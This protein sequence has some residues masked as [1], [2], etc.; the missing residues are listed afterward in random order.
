[1]KYLITFLILTLLFFSC[2]P[3]D[4]SVNNPLPTLTPPEWIKGSWNRSVD[5]LNS[6]KIVISNDDVI[7]KRTS[8]NTNTTTSIVDSCTKNNIQ[9][10]EYTKYNSYY[11]LTFINDKNEVNEIYFAK[12]SDNEIRFLTDIS[13]TPK[14]YIRE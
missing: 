12:I 5:S 9:L 4:D 14:T 7:I 11:N 13:P 10:S 8:N 2:K 3:E 1:M 6:E